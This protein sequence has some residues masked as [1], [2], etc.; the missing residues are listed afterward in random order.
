MPAN[1][2]N[3]IFKR[4]PQ[5]EHARQHQKF[6][7]NANEHQSHDYQIHSDTPQTASKNRNRL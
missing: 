7:K 6:N 3:P 5:Y 4:L 1:I 2:K